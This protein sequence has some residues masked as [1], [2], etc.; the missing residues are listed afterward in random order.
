ML[1]SFTNVGRALGLDPKKIRRVTPFWKVLNVWVDGHRPKFMTLKMFWSAFVLFRKERS[2]GAVVSRIEGTNMWDVLSS[3]SQDWQNVTLHDR[4]VEC[5]CNDFEHQQKSF[6]FSNLWGV[7][8]FAC[9]H[10]Y[11]VL[12]KIGYSSLSAYIKR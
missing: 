5:T 1:T 6:E 4:S 2:R 11:A 3:T 12:N 8:H 9:K 10:V 7:K